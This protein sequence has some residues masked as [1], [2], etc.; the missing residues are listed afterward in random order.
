[1]IFSYIGS[2]LI[3][4]RNKYWY[5]KKVKKFR[6]IWRIYLEYFGRTKRKMVEW[7]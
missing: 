1:L 3:K 6:Y 4:W 5:R 2:I 7:K